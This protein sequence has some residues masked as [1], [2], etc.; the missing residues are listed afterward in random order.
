M[1]PFYPKDGG[2]LARFPKM[3][4]RC[5]NVEPALHWGNVLS[6]L[7]KHAPNDKKGIAK[8]KRILKGLK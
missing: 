8:A 3:E 6:H 2:A 5:P 1:E 7:Q 4:T